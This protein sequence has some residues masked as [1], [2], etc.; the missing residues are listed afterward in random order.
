MLAAIA[1]ALRLTSD[2]RDHL[3]HLAG[4]EPSRD[5]PAI[6]HV[7][8]GL[9]LVLDRLVARP[10]AQR[11]IVWRYFTDPSARDIFP[12]EDLDNAARTA[13]ADLRAALARRLDDARPRT[14]LPE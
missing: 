12:V 1:R 11:N 9:L 10:P 8:P 6:E 14:S 4:E 5:R 13:V 3:F 7:G 2:E